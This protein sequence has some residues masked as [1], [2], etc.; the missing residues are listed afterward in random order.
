MDRNNNMVEYEDNIIYF[1]KIY[2]MSHISVIMFTSINISSQI[3]TI[4]SLRIPLSN[5]ESPWT[6]P[7][8][9]KVPKYGNT[10]VTGS[11]LIETYETNRRQSVDTF[12]YKISARPSGTCWAAGSWAAAAGP[13]A[14]GTAAGRS[15]PPRPGRGPDASSSWGTAARGAGGAGR[16]RAAAGSPRRAGRAARTTG[17]TTR[18]W[19]RASGSTSCCRSSSWRRP[20]P[21]ECSPSSCYL[22]T[23]C[24]QI[25]AWLS[26]TAGTVTK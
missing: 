24:R 6:S 11:S 18:R 5:G 16:G 2:V 4:E 26:L 10:A 7:N 22:P 13:G 12:N 15:P 3:I 8:I 14:A 19:R 20:P 1:L 21:T 23:R 25:S 17:R 9:R